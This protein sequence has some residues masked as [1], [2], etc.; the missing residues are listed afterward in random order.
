MQGRQHKEIAAE[1]GISIHTVKLYATRAYK[2]L[3]VETALELNALFLFGRDQKLLSI[4]V[5]A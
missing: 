5:A 3:G 1:L 2:K 4:F